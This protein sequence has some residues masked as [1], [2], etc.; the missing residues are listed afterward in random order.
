MASVRVE[1]KTVPDRA[2]RDNDDMGRIVNMLTGFKI[3]L[4]R[5]PVAAELA[6]LRA[7]LIAL[8]TDDPPS[9]TLVDLV[10][11]R[12]ISVWR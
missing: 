4:R 6:A 3:A 7:H 5:P 11:G 10:S 2:K 1:F 9:E 8:E 12:R